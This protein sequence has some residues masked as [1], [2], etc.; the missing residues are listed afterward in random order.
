MALR[1][2]SVF[3]SN[4]AHALN[5]AR[6]FAHEQ[7]C[8]SHSWTF[9]GFTY[10][11]AN[12]GDW[13]RASLATR[14]IF[15]QRF[16]NML[17]GFE[18]ICAHRFYPLRTTDKGNGPIVCGFHHWRYDNHGHAIGIPMCQQQ[19]GTVSRGLGARLN[20]IEIAT[21]GSLIFGRFPMSKQGQ[22][23]EDFLGVGFP[24]L[25][26]LSRPNHK[27]LT[28]SHPLAANWKLGLQITF[29]DYHTVA[30]HP[31]TFGKT[32]YLDREKL[33]YAQFGFHSALINSNRPKVLE[34]ISAGCADSSFRPTCYCIF[35]IL[36]NFLLAL[37]R[38]DGDIFNCCIQQFVPVAHDRSLL[39][40]W[41]YPAPFPVEGAWHARLWRHLSDP[42]RRPLV[43][44][45]ARRVMREDNQICENLQQVAHQ[46][47]R[48]PYLAALEERIGWFEQSYRKLVAEGEESEANREDP[49]EA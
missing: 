9:L 13:F 28:L 21:C 26:V 23:L 10:D 29:D 7:R 32:G 44:H 5:D 34:E 27:T 47:E 41:V 18:N 16:G 20:S 39:R 17:K 11:V 35:H 12:D 42:I 22:S 33:S 8:L 19:F 30:V 48:P 2:D 3:A 36:P 43:R 15:V 6:A 14:S 37:F 45:Y 31:T 24:I 1:G 40:A 38:S 46:I 4:W 25:E 49:R